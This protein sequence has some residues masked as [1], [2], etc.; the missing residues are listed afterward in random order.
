VYNGITSGTPDAVRAAVFNDAN[1][2]ISTLEQALST[3]P[4]VVNTSP[5]ATGIPSDLTV[6]EDT[7]SNVNLSAATFA[8]AD[9]DT[10]TVT[11]SVD[12]GTFS[13][14]A[15]GSGVGVTETLVNATTIT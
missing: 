3:T 10:L 15:D 8:D 1:W 6:T 5:T 14:P 11:L 4:F 9:G 7:A 12:A 2:T 13:T